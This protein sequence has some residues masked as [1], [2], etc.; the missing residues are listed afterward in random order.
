MH[1]LRLLLLAVLV[2][3]LAFVALRTRPDSAADA[4]LE[5]S[6]VLADLDGARV[7]RLLVEH[8]GR[9]E[10]FVLERDGSGTWLMTEPLAWPAEGAVARTLLTHLSTLP[11]EELPGV[12]PADVGLDPPFVRLEL[13]ERVAGD[14]RVQVVR[15]GD[16]DLGREKVHVA[17]GPVGSGAPVLRVPRAL[18]DTLDLGYESFRSKRLVDFE[19]SQVTEIVR[20]GSTDPPTGAFQGPG[21]EHPEA[22]T[23]ESSDLTFHA[24]ADGGGWFV[25]EPYRARLE[26][27]IVFGFL[28]VLSQLRAASF[29]LDDPESLEPFGL[30]PPW[31]EIDVNLGADDWIGLEFGTEPA[32]ATRD[33]GDR[34]WYVRREG[35]P[36]VFTVNPSTIYSFD[37]PLEEMLDRN[38]FQ[39]RREDVVGFRVVCDANGI[40]FSR[41]TGHWRVGP[42]ALGGEVAAIPSL[43]ADRPAVEDVLAGFEGMVLADF[44]EP[45]RD[46]EPRGE[47][48]L[49]LT[50]EREVSVLLGPPLE[51]Y[52]IEGHTLR[53]SGES[54]WAFVVE[55]VCA[56]AGR[57]PEEFMSLTAFSLDEHL[58]E[59]IEVSGLGRAR[60]WEREKGRGL[61]QPAGVV[62]ED[63]DF[64]LLVD[65][66]RAPVVRRWALDRGLDGLDA[67]LR[68]EL[69]PIDPRDGQGFV[70]WRE[71]EAQGAWLEHEGRLGEVSAELYDGLQDLL[72]VIGR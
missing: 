30:D 20:R 8:E 52:G 16:H 61:W 42:S 11:A 49:E 54:R 43:L 23:R 37:Q 48:V 68:V 17:L 9:A 64:A 33:V 35:A 3:G 22:S 46:L 25:T 26:P 39:V 15:I 4:V 70:L 40:A 21:P 59:R 50:G 19:L 10:R 72:L 36:N 45:G 66:L 34:V 63:R 29:H 24:Q 31:F 51:H 32:M 47:L 71:A 28:R 53:R 12:A 56:T 7:A 13:T 57:R 6:H 44:L 2:A 18:R 65:G 69:Q 41:E 5:G 55:D 58:L 14:D 27:A 1:G 38:L 60:V 62:A 67:P